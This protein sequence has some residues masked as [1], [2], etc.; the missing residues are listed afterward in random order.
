MN[1]YIVNSE[2]PG[3][4]LV[5]I[6]HLGMTRLLL[7]WPPNVTPG[8]ARGR[9][10]PRASQPKAQLCAVNTRKIDKRKKKNSDPNAVN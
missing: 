8:T 2:F 9:F 10:E 3:Q 4:D 1:F 6:L 5:L 7:E